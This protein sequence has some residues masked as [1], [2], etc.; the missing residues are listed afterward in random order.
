[1]AKKPFHIENINH[2]CGSTHNRIVH[3]ANVNNVIR[4]AL[5]SMPAGSYMIHEL[6][7]YNI[8]REPLRSTP[9]YRRARTGGT[10]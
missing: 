8:Y 3:Y 1:M 2:P 4:F 9:A 10:S 5:P 6:D 7:P